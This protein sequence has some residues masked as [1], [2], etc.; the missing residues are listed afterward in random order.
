MIEISG[1]IRK[2]AAIIGKSLAALL[3]AS[4]PV[5]LV[6]SASLV[7]HTEFSLGLPDNSK[8]AAISGSDQICSAGHGR[9]FIPIAEIP[10]LLKSAFLASEEP[11]FYERPAVLTEYALSALR[12][13][14][15]R[16]TT[17]ANHLARCLTPSECCKGPDWS[18]GTLVLLNRV[19]RILPKDTIFEIYLNDIYL[20][21]G[22]YGVADAAASYFGK[23]LGELD[24]GE[25]AFIVT[26]AR[27]RFASK[28][29]RV[30]ID[31]RNRV[32]ARMRDAGVISEAV[33]TSAMTAPL[34]LRNRPE[35]PTPSAG[36]QDGPS[37]A[38]DK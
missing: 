38:P 34:M 14:R 30:E 21:R 26:R 37:P 16:P 12:N 6:L 7:W 28:D 11:E 27:Y 20:G 24:P 1:A 35:A 8:L 2:P 25:M 19:D 3:M 22:S 15:P 32:I 9:T 31:R 18:L 33:A 36:D 29:Q 13:R 4:G 17:I 23:S 5:L 10:T